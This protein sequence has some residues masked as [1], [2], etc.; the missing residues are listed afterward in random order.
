MTAA[1]VGHRNWFDA[2]LWYLTRCRLS[3]EA[4]RALAQSTVS[5]LRGWKGQ[6]RKCIV[7]DLDNTL[8][9]GLAGEDGL[10]GIALGE[11][12]IGLAFAEFQE[13]LLNLTRKGIL[14]AVCSKNNEDD[15]LAKIERLLLDPGYL[16]AREARLRAEYRPRAWADCVQDL[17]GACGLAQ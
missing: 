3:R 7:L 2:R 15:A 9:G 6:T 1:N 4:M 14:L 16:T 17:V 12:G 13:E 8:W 10:Q 5:L 11:E